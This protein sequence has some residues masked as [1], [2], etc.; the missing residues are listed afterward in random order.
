LLTT[1]VL[2]QK[3]II[4][5]KDMLISTAK[6]CKENQKK[7]DQPVIEGVAKESKI[8]RVSEKESW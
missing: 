7:K 5:K 2:L 3:P 1:T 8:N 4:D 6:L